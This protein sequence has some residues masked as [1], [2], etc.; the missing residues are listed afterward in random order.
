MNGQVYAQ[1]CG[2]QLIV[3]VTQSVKHGVQDASAGIWSL[4]L[5]S[6]EW[7]EFEGGDEMVSGNWH[8]FAM[9]V[10][11][12][13]FFLFGDER[14]DEYFSNVLA[15]DLQ[16]YGLVHAPPPTLAADFGRLF[17]DAATSDFLIRTGGEDDPP[18]HCHRTVLLARWP[19]FAKMVN[20]G[21]TESFGTS[22]T[23]PEPYSTVRAFLRY[24]YTDDLD[25]YIPVD[26]VADLMVLG[27]MYFLSRLTSLCCNRLHE[28]I[29]IENVARVYHRACVI[30]EHGLKKRS[31]RFIDQHFGRVSK[32]NGFRTLPKEAL[33][34]FLDSLPEKAKIS[35]D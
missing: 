2:D 29:D 27:N 5:Q 17:D 7:Q 28:K 30:E 12:P 31:A 33:F 34:D 4:D 35:L 15:V 9:A 22:I 21:M 26:T 14:D 25:D 24:L 10:N 13:H 23:I 1:L 20:S 11:T 18:I 16:E 6:F 3:V 8:Y 19:H 32:T